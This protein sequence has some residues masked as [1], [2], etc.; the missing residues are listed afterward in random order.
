MTPLDFWLRWLALAWGAPRSW[1]ELF[2]PTW[3]VRWE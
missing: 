2:D 3:R 1:R